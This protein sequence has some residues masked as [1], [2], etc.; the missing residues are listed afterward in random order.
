MCHSWRDEEHWQEMLAREAK[1]E[2]T[3]LIETE[4]A[5]EEPAPEREEE[6]EGELVR[7]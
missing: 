5:A 3:R 7:I 4:P 2:P 6:R 1:D